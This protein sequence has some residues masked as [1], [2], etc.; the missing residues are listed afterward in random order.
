MNP[1]KTLR[2]IGLIAP[3]ALLTLHGTAMQASES[4]VTDTAISTADMPPRPIVSEI[5]NLS[6]PDQSNYVGSVAAKVES[7]LGFPLIGTIAQRLVDTGDLVKKGDVLIRLDPAELRADL[8]AAQ[9][10]ETVA[11]VQLRNAK[12]AESRARALQ[13]RGVD[14]TTDV[15]AAQL[16]LKTSE[17]KLEQA[18]AALARTADN[19]ALAELTAPHDGVVTG[20]FVEPG[21]TVSAGQPVVQL[22]DTHDR[23]I[24][25]DLPEHALAGMDLGSPFHTAL[26]ADSNVSTT[27]I[28]TRIAPVTKRTTRQLH[29]T[30]QDPPPSYRLGALVRVNRIIVAASSISL[31]AAAV[32][33]YNGAPHVWVID[34]QTNAAH[35]RAVTPGASY[36]D[37]LRITAG[38]T[39]GEEV[40]IKGI[41]SL[42]EGQIV[43]PRVHP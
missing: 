17:A 10:G 22:A 12:D 2:L 9:A 15:E 28:L 39:S 35:L 16:I 8:R 34:R 43:G 20:I 38:L 36:G 11:E 13:D 1:L 14:S 26:A 18:R 7:N 40:A 6:Q 37:R 21:T 3:V 31:P 33:D 41:H 23:E 4:A 25:I 5:V 29:L 30:L 19:L 27:A 24:V 42:T 32:L